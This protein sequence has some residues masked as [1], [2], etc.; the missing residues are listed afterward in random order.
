MGDENNSRAIC[1]IALV[2]PRPLA[3]NSCQSLL[4]IVTCRSS[5][6]DRYRQLS[7]VVN[8]HSSTTVNPQLSILNCHSSATVTRR[9]LST[10]VI[11]TRRSSIVF[12]SVVDD[13][14]VPS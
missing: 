13:G 3:A 5:I 7:T 4:A 10:I 1:F 12:S 14:S 2:D 11:V 6:V 9:Q 8:C